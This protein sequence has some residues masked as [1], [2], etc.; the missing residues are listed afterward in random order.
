MSILIRKPGAIRDLYPSDLDSD[1]APKAGHDS[2]SVPASLAEFLNER[3]LI[4]RDDYLRMDWARKR[5]EASG[6]VSMMMET[7]TTINKIAGENIVDM[8]SF[9]PPEPILC[10]F[11]YVEGGTEYF[12]RLELQSGML[13]LSFAERNCRDTV[14]NDFVRWV[15]RLADIEPVKINVKLVHEFQE[16]RVS[17][18]QVQEWFKYLIS[19][20]ARS[21]TPSLC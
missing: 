17:V 13:T 4:T 20:L 6:I 11:I 3:S 7:C 19:G 14:S 15:H 5:A 21:Y 18:E 2:T 9:L 8:H 16:I 10:C 12:M 1:G